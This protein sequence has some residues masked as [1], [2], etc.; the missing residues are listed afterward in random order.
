MRR[1]Y[2]KKLPFFVTLSG[3]IALTL[4]VFNSVRLYASLS[5]WD[6]I[7][8]FMPSFVPFYL[9]FT[10]LIWLFAWFGVFVA[11]KFRWAQTHL[12]L[13]SVSFFYAIYYWAD[14]LCLQSAVERE[15]TIF[16]FVTTLFFL[17]VVIIASFQ[18][19]RRVS[20]AENTHHGA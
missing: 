18:W 2:A 12:F 13:L 10:G 1:K 15:G 16:A 8:A 6:T 14:R 20:P 4:M 5:Q 3:G 19:K 9:A 11:I 17:G 7:V